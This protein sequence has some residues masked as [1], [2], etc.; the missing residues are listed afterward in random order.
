V[1]KIEYNVCKFLAL[2]IVSHRRKLP[3]DRTRPRVSE[4]GY[5][6]PETI[7]PGRFSI[8]QALKFL[9]EHRD[10][11]EETGSA[12]SI[13]RR[14]NLDVKSVSHV[15]LHFGVF[16]VERPRALTGGAENKD[17]TPF[18]MKVADMADDVYKKTW[19]TFNIIGVVITL[20][21]SQFIELD[22]ATLNVFN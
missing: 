2:Q 11:P 1:L 4:F 9:V 15:L 7:R 20:R 22:Y 12:D 5:V 6:E 17:E 13:A 21:V 3:E 19:S 14:Y 8:R 10:D 16:N 18:S